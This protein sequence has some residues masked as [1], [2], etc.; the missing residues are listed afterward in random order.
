MH[1]ERITSPDHPLYPQAM[2]L[3]RSSFPAHELREEASQ[4]AIL[5][6]SAYH[7][8]LILD[9][10]TFVGEVLFWEVA[11]FYYIEHFCIL[12]EMRNHRYGQRALELLRPVP[13]ILEID[14]PVDDLSIR[15][16]GFYERCGFVENPYRHIHPPYHRG[17][18]GHDLVVMSCPRKLTPAEYSAFSS[19]LNEVV[20]Q[21]VF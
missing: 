21:D 4:T 8:T 6:D 14:P 5:R 13:L 11:G 18:H 16:K 10:G 2:A 20:M 15:R 3:Y 17:N 9:E 12:P 1:F 19:Y 7:F